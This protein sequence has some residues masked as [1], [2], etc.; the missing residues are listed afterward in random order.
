[1]LPF[2]VVGSISTTLSVLLLVT[3]PPRASQNTSP[4]SIETP[5]TQASHNTE[6][7][8]SCDQDVENASVSER[9]ENE[10]EGETTAL[11]GNSN[12]S[13]GTTT[14]PHDVQLGYDIEFNF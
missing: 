1:M 9:G 8:S 7:P 12:T 2:L 14:K 4:Q 3:I 10:E 11:V 6:L 5:D 13:N